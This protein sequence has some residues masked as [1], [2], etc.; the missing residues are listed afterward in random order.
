VLENFSVIC[1]YDVKFMLRNL[2]LETVSKEAIFCGNFPFWGCKIKFCGRL[3]L[4]RPKGETL[5][6]NWLRPIRA[7]L[8]CPSRK[9]SKYPLSQKGDVVGTES[10]KL[11]KSSLLR[12]EARSDA[13]AQVG[14]LMPGNKH[15]ATLKPTAPARALDLYRYKM[16]SLP[17]RF[18]NW[19]FQTLFDNFQF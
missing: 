15:H 4:K 12:L 6:E 8:V 2:E 9:H 18:A 17:E 7:I 19:L 10:C 13:I 5:A 1:Q 11:M 3:A 14:G 16:Q